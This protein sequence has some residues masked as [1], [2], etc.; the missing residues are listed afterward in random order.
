MF[1]MEKHCKSDAEVYR[2]L[3]SNIEYS[4][5]DDSIE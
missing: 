4:S 3:K 1:V 5:F 2:S